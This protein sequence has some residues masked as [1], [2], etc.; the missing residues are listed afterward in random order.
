MTFFSLLSSGLS[1]HLVIVFLDLPAP[2]DAIDYAKQS[3]K[4]CKAFIPLSLIIP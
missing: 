4:V 1:I 3:L 2:W